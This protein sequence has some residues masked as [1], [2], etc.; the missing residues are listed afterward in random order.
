MPLYL[1]SAMG[2]DPW[3]LV[4]RTDGHTGKAI[5]M[6]SAVSHNAVT[7]CRDSFELAHS[8]AGRRWTEK[9]IPI[10]LLFP[11]FIHG[12]GISSFDIIEE[13]SPGIFPLALKPRRFVPNGLGFTIR[14][15]RA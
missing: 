6:D 7:S 2:K 5:S 14:G 4:T 9:A 12:R 3:R 8:E 13:K 10:L 1:T 11:V 15:R